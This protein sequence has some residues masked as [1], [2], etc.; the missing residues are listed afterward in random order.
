MAGRVSLPAA[1]GSYASVFDRG[2]V[3][4][5]GG[6]PVRMVGSMLDLTERKRLEE[7]LREIASELSNANRQ[8]DEFLAMLAHELR[9][10]LAPLRTALQIIRLSPDRE[11][12]EQARG[13]MERQLV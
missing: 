1:D 4:R 9:N 12:R 8:K 2:R 5:D 6:K 13:M 10:P 3:V 7:E 11:A